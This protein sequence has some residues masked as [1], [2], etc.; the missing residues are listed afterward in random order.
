MDRQ[1]IQQHQYSLLT[2]CQ[3]L[4][5]L[6]QQVDGLL[7]QIK[8]T[9]TAASTAASLSLTLDD[10]NQCSLLQLPITRLELALSSLERCP[11]FHK[12]QL[13]QLSL[14][15]C[16]HFHYQAATSLSGTT[17]ESN[18]GSGNRLLIKP[19]TTTTTQTSSTSSPK[20]AAGP[21][22]PSTLTTPNKGANN[23][24]ES[25]ASPQ[26]QQQQHQQQHIT[27]DTKPTHMVLSSPQ[28]KELRR[29]KQQQHQHQHHHSQQHKQHHQFKHID[30]HILV[31][32][33]YL[34][35]L[36]DRNPT[37]W[38][39]AILQ[40]T[41]QTLAL[42]DRLSTINTPL[43]QLHTVDGAVVGQSASVMI[44]SNLRYLSIRTLSSILLH[45]TKD[46][47]DRFLNQSRLLDG[48]PISWITSFICAKYPLMTL[49]RSLQTCLKCLD[50]GV[51]SKA[52]QFSTLEY[53][54]TQ[55][56]EIMGHTISN[57]I[58]Q[59]QQGGGESTN[60]FL[61]LLHQ[62]PVLITISTPIILNLLGAN[63]NYTTTTTDLLNKLILDRISYFE[64]TTFSNIITLLYNNNDNNSNKSFSSALLSSIIEQ[65]ERSWIFGQQG[66]SPSDDDVGN[67]AASPFK[68]ILQELAHSI[69]L[70]CDLIIQQ[71]TTTMH[72][73]MMD[74]TAIVA[75]ASSKE[76]CIQT[77]LFFLCKSSPN[78][79]HHHFVHFSRQFSIVHPSAV[80]DCV[81]LAFKTIDTFAQADAERLLENILYLLQLATDDSTHALTTQ[82]LQATLSSWWVL[83]PMM[84]HPIPRIQQLPLLILKCALDLVHDRPSI[85]F[86]DLVDMRILGERILKIVFAQLLQMPVE[87]R[88]IQQEMQRINKLNQLKHIYHSICSQS[89]FQ[90]HWGVDL[91]LDLI[92]SPSTAD[93]RLKCPVTLVVAPANS[94][95]HMENEQ[96]EQQDSN[97]AN[98]IKVDLILY[99]T[100]PLSQPIPLEWNTKETAAAAE[101]GDNESTLLEVNFKRKTYQYKFHDMNNPR[102]QPFKNVRVRFD[103]S[104]DVHDRGTR[105]TGLPA[106]YNQAA[107]QA[108]II[109]LLQSMMHD[110]DAQ[111]TL[112]SD[113]LAILSEHI[114]LRTLPSHMN[115]S[116]DSYQDI[117]PKPSTFDRDIYVRK[118]F[119]QNDI[120]WDILEIVSLDG[121]EL[122]KCL[123]LVKAL[124]VNAISYWYAEKYVVS[125][126]KSSQFRHTCQLVRIIANAQLVPS[127]LG[128]SSEL[129]DWITTEE[130]SFI[131]MTMWNFIKY[132]QPTPSQYSSSSTSASSSTT[133]T[134][135]PISKRDFYDE[136]NTLATPNLEMYTQAL[137]SIFHNHIKQLAPL[138]GRY[139]HQ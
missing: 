21:N 25:F 108:E 64:T 85:G 31:T 49:S 112:N 133:T 17:P 88:D 22:S 51:E 55:F 99:P 102:H 32:H 57:H 28:T 79:L 67:V 75:L 124:L 115:P 71:P 82:T 1:Q 45:L 95:T 73:R 47:I 62:C 104:S 94:P 23:N 100:A 19:T 129:F 42:I 126:S 58:K 107:N 72:K 96:Q 61:K 83:L 91:I 36:L 6:C 4:G 41:L 116:Y 101:A 70:F 92:L 130:I 117:L 106:N 48:M 110:R 66:V 12:Q 120:L 134:W 131:L 123:E 40:W 60:K 76:T 20:H 125:P 105:A 135:Q 26:T 2:D 33:E 11:V 87:V 37:G 90:L 10:T 80:Q 38:Y 54:S 113:K 74:L 118:L 15:Y 13:S 97:C 9:T 122:C 29:H 137:K 136:G 7:R 138:Y 24:N 84:A 86:K 132:H 43:H 119:Q 68:V 69:K 46:G 30:E 127:P 18:I 5:H 78:H 89:L 14:L 121:R 3:R 16:N 128:H 111:K 27:S 93:D 98:R 35:S 52:A 8:S 139:I 56:T 114:A 63:N 65:L 39:T 50:D 81:A 53:L 77:L 44:Q 34:V 109:A 59:Q 103:D